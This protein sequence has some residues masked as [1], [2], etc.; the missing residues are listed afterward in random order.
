M[1]LTTK[2]CELLL[3]M[4]NGSL[5]MLYHSGI[6]IAVDTSE[7][8]DTIKAEITKELIEAAKRERAQK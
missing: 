4:V 3:N 2:Q 1:I 5:T 7:D 6:P 8:I